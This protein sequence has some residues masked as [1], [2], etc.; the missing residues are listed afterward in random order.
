LDDGR[1]DPLQTKWRGIP[2][3]DMECQCD[4]INWLNF[5]RIVWAK[6]AISGDLIIVQLILSRSFRSL[7]KR[8]LFGRIKGSSCGSSSSPS[9]FRHLI[10]QFSLRW[11]E[12]DEMDEILTRRVLLIVFFDQIDF[13]SAIDFGSLSD[14]QLQSD[15]FRPIPKKF[16]I[17][18]SLPA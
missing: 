2:G 7:L 11:T 12:Q 13:Q 9:S 18:F 16:Q 15:L 17:S 1:S 8:R 4:Y 5:E 6:T 3:S 10:F 14:Y